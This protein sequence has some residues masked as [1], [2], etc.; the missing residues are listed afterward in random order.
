M[1]RFFPLLTLLMLLPSAGCNEIA[2]DKEPVVRMVFSGSVTNMNGQP[3]PGLKVEP[4]AVNWLTEDPS[5]EL[6]SIGDSVL[7]DQAGVYRFDITTKPW[8]NVVFT[9]WDIDGPENG[10]FQQPAQLWWYIDYSKTH[11][12]V[13]DDTWDFGTISFEVPRII[14][15]DNNLD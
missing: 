12:E 5:R 3:I 6:M 11:L 2:I 8:R 4:Y 14:L 9:V 7:T 15:N 1:K 13:G 10:S